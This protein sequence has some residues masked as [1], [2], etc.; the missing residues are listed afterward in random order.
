MRLFQSD[1]DIRL[2][3]TEIYLDPAEPR[4][5]GI[6]S[7]GHSDHIG[8][9]DH[10][11]ATAPTAS[12]LR[13][14]EGRDLKGTELPYR[15]PHLIDGF[16]VELYPAGHV[17]GSA[18]VRVSNANGSFVYTGD[19]KLSAS[20]TAEPAEVPEADAV[21]MESTYGQSPD[22]VFPSR[23]QLREQMTAARRRFSSRTPS[24]KR[25]KRRPCSAIA[26]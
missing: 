1:P 8:R 3:G 26:A 15:E 13:I 6:I 23:E 12:F 5:V 17:H 20:F 9:H 11:I 21:I 4:P 22:W 16:T 25:R 24:A 10:F 19:F 7:H 18:M 14:R 2:P